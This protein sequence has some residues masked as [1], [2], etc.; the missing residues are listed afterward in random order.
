[1]DSRSTGFVG[2]QRDLLL[3]GPVFLVFGLFL[4][5]DLLLGL[6]L[7]ASNVFIVAVRVVILDVFDNQTTVRC[8]CKAAIFALRF[9]VF[10]A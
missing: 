7:V 1:M 5:V 2:V 10:L 6:V 3:R 8:S 4:V 9:N